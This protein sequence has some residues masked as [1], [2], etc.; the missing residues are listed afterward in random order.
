MIWPCNSLFSRTTFEDK[1]F[2]Y[3][4]PYNTRLVSLMSLKMINQKNMI[5][6]KKL[7]EHIGVRSKKIIL[8]VFDSNLHILPCKRLEPFLYLSI[9]YIFSAFS[10]LSI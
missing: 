7:S 6:E 8:Q 4:V 2:V 10:K 3:R 1:S 5:D 9:F